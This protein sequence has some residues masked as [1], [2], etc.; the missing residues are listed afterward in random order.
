MTV[1]PSA[2]SAS[3]ASPTASSDERPA[4]PVPGDV[5]QPARDVAEEAEEGD[6]D[7]GEPGAPLVGV[8][9]DDERA[10]R[11]HER[12]QHPD[13]PLVHASL[14]ANPLPRLP[15]RFLEHLLS[16]GSAGG[17]RESAGRFAIL[18]S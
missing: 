18:A 8:D 4:I 17:L 7:E 13:A 5:D 16:I 3:S 9:P 2:T 15:G 11:E 12:E 6:A 1:N 14:G 10:E